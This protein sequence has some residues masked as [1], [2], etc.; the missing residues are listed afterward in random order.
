MATSDRCPRCGA[1]VLP[2]ERFCAKCGAPLDAATPAQ[3]REAPVQEAPVQQMPI[4]ETLIQE[5]PVQ[6]A[7][8]QTVPAPAG[9]PRTIDQLGAW[10]AAHGMPLEK[11][12]FFVGVDYREPR[13]FGIYR[14]GDS[15]V[16]Y[17]NKAD[18]SRAVRYHGPDEAYAVNELYEKLLSECHNRGIYPDGK[19]Q[20]T[21]RRRKAR[22]RNTRLVVVVVILVILIAAV[23]MFI[24]E[25]AH[26]FDGY[27]QYD[28]GYY[29]RYGDSWYYD[30]VYDW[31]PVDNFPYDTSDDYYLGDDYNAAWGA[32]DFKD[33][34]A[35]DQ[36]QADR[37]SS[38]SS[39]FSSW[40]AGGTD[41]SSDW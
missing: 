34:S 28:D 16:V 39:D 2:Q 14:D 25:R 22:K 1:L 41:W 18:G 26:R 4:Q 6:K 7:P 31:V 11:M 30:D 3:D 17:K 36:I 5:A 33:S 8:V 23:G 37:D 24:G 38:G 35:W 32:D 9:K 27:Y 19:P 15:F 29:Y 21:E 13:A 40:D 20:V 12:R 10:C